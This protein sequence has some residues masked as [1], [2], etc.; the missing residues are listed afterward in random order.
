MNDR[1]HLVIFARYPV[2]GGGKRRLAADIGAVQAVRFQRARLMTLIHRFGADPRWTTWLAVT[3][4]RSGPWPPHIGAIGQGRGDLGQ[5]MSTI[6]R[7]L[8]RGRAIII[9]TD[10]PSLAPYDIA[11]AFN[12]LGSHDAVF[13]P[14]ADG[15]YWLVGLKRAPKIRLPFADVRWSTRHALA[16]TK[17]NLSDVSIGHVRTLEDVDDA[18]SLAQHSHWGRVCPPSFR[19]AR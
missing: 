10:I 17:R 16:D 13:G 3:P 1:R 5:R 19:G 15:G 18:R 9:G 8:P 7:R 2:A 11:E 14:A 4:D 12:A 6:M